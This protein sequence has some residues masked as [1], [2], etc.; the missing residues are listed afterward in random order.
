MDEDDA[1]TLIA[2]AWGDLAGAEVD[3]KTVF[4]RVRVEILF[5]ST[6]AALT[7]ATRLSEAA[8]RGSKGK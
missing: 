8:S 7:T 1:V 5:H 3:V 2:K 4:Q 6:D